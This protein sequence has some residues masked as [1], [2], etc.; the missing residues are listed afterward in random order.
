MSSL[1]RCNLLL[2][3]QETIE[4]DFKSLHP[5]IIYAVLGIELPDGFDPYAISPDNFELPDTPEIRQQLRN[6]S[7]IGL[8]ILLNASNPYQALGALET[9][10]KEAKIA[11]D[12]DLLPD[13][14]SLRNVI[15]ALKEINPEIAAKFHSGAGLLLQNYDSNIAELVISYFTEKGIPVIPIHDSFIVAKEFEQE[16]HYIMKE[17]YECIVGSTLNCIVET[18]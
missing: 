12:F 11:Y 9:E 7:K 16:M 8:L 6:L 18:K 1:S 14:L 15:S 2:N 5:R 4:V 3:G 17:A 10:F 13:N